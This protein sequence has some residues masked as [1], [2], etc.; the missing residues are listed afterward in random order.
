MAEIWS[1]ILPN[2]GSIVT[3]IT[4]LTLFYKIGRWMQEVEDRLEKL[5]KNPIIVAGN[6]L[7][8]KAL[9]QK[10]DLT[11]KNEK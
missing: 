7:S 2:L 8:A 1:I 5:E 6:K 11:Q 4:L 3:L 10:S 9:S